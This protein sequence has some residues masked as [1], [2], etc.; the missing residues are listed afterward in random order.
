MKDLNRFPT[1]PVPVIPLQNIIL[2]PENVSS[3]IIARKSSIRA[4]TRALEGDQWV[5]LVANQNPTQ[6][7][8]IDPK[9]LYDIGTLAKIESFTGDSTSGYRIVVR[10]GARFKVESYSTEKDILHATGLILPDQM[11][12][13]PETVKALS[14]SLKSVALE[15]VALLPGDHKNLAESIKNLEDAEALTHF[16]SQYI[17]C[18]LTEK[19]AL[20]ANLSFRTRSLKLLDL[21]VKRRE[22]LKLQSDIGEK[23]SEKM[24]KA[25]REA[26]LREQMK[27]IQSEL[28]G[29]ESDE[30]QEPD[31]KTK[32]LE[33]KM[34]PEAE[35]IALQ[36]AKRLAAMG[37]Q[38][39]ESHII[40]NYLDL[41]LALPWHESETEDLDL[42]A[43][44]EILDREHFGLTEIKKRIMQHLAV[45]KMRKEKKGSIL[46]LVGPPGVGKTSLGQSIARSLNRKFIRASFGGVRDEAEIRGHRRTYIGA[47][48]GRIIDAVKRAGQ[49][50]PVFM[51][52]EIDKMSN[53]WGGDPSSALLEALDPEQNHSFRDH[54]LD[55]PFDLSN[56]LFIATANS[57]DTISA[58]LLDRMEVIQL[59][60]YS[61]D[62]KLHIAQNHL[63]SKQLKEHGM[64]EEQIKISEPALRRLISAYT[65]EAGV[66]DLQR[67]IAHLLRAS[68]EKVLA[69]GATLPL[70]IEETDLNEILG[71]AKFIFDKVEVLVPPGVVTGLAWT[72]MGG[73]ILF[74][75]SGAMPGTG[76]LTVTGQLGEVM[77]ESVQIAL[78]LVRSHLAAVVPNF[79][80]NKIDLHVHVPAGGI[81]K[82]GPSAGITMVTALAS[83]L[84]KIPVS[85]KLAMTGEVTLRGAVL[86][87]GG[88]KEKITAAHRAGITSIILSRK[89]EPDLSDLSKEVFEGIT[90][91]LVDSIDE[92]LKIA[93]GLK[94]VLP[95]LILSSPE[96]SLV[97]ADVAS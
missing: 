37:Q 97:S 62:E 31:Y 29:G 32:I 28:S 44:R 79:E 12:V 93:L 42:Q 24:G 46:L 43:A 85:T 61:Q 36:E 63:W 70:Q 90:F 60:G 76:Q 78:S 3:L 8:V 94:P 10:V 68:A 50:N 6:D 95:N 57:L 41:L 5:F 91:H 49:N 16:V 35:K 19:Q 92:V 73:D 17:E 80:L 72:P 86:P 4:V 21:L 84:T 25:Q 96:V 30:N 9:Q 69:L 75:E 27:A 83:L 48:P 18:T 87:V 55:V 56:V 33:A 54:Y 20:L 7:Q 59:S 58:P 47:L 23:L 82:D 14:E 53:G 34:S 11:D 65:R 1:H 71:R 40:R 13:T 67:K 15:I 64:N 66:R 74:V 38:S 89:N 81:P 26:I 45:M 88:I 22:E 51:L 77:K 52:D 2:F 39:A